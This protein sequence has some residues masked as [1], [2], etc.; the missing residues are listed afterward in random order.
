MKQARPILS[1]AFLFVAAL[2]SIACRER[3]KET[4]A[5]PAA[6]PAPVEASDVATRAPR[7]TGGPAVIWL[8]LDGLDWELLDRLAAEGRMPNWKRLVAEGW[9][10]K[11][12]SFYPLISPILWTTAATGVAPD[13]HR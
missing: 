13:V 1:T 12:E 6:R 3:E 2:G 5:A 9:S 8:G 7:T 10:G 11:L 4:I